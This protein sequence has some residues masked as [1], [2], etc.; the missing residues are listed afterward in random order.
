MIAAPTYGR[1]ARHRTVRA[2]IEQNPGLTALQIADRCSHLY[3]TDP[4]F[5]VACCR[6]LRALHKGTAVSKDTS[7]RPERWYA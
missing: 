4:G 6:D 5:L 7:E 3:G 1:D 2:F